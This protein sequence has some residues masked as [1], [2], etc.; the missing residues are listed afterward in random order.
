MGGS[1]G[2]AARRVD[3]VLKSRRGSS[4]HRWMPVVAYMTVMGTRPDESTLKTP[5]GSLLFRQKIT[6]VP[7]SK[8]TI[9]FSPVYT[10]HIL[11]TSCIDTYH[12]YSFAF[13]GHIPKDSYTETSQTQSAM[14]GTW[15]Y[16]PET[17]EVQSVR[18]GFDPVTARSSSH[19]A[20]DRCHEKKVRLRRPGL[21]SGAPLCARPRTPGRRCGRPIQLQAKHANM[22]N[23]SVAVET[24]T[25]AKDAGTT[26]FAVNILAPAPSHHAGGRAA[27]SLQRVTV[28][29]AQA[30]S[31]EGAHQSGQGSTTAVLP[32]LQLQ[33]RRVTECWD[34]LTSPRSAP[35]TASI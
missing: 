16:D 19:Q 1:L 34:S 15:K 14:F 4:Q 24:R 17:D 20:C 23:S 30:P 29:Q 21:T 3:G 7:T 33:P 22:S 6:K 35:R 12:P 13:K 18:N 32:E 8:R 11:N 10:I 28:L 5:R 27:A 26:T 9:Q 2:S 25:A 31:E